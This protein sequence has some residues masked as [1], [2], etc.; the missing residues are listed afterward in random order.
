MQ[1][2]HTALQFITSILMEGNTC[3][4]YA[5]HR[6]TAKVAA[7]ETPTLRVFWVQLCRPIPV[8]HG[9]PNGAEGKAPVLPARFYRFSYSAAAHCHTEG[10]SF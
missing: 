1:V 3:C 5:V 10:R 4:F 7:S 9:S 2:F 8:V 6:D